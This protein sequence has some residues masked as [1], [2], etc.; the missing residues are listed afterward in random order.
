[1]DIDIVLRRERIEV[2]VCDFNKNAIS[3]TLHPC[4]R[5]ED[6]EL[7]LVPNPKRERRAFTLFWK[8][9]TRFPVRF[10]LDSPVLGAIVS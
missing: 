5:V 4:R 2:P 3:S 7:E 1:M 10:C 9:W 8:F 6:C